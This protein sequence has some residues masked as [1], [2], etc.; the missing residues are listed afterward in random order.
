[1]AN[2]KFTPDSA[3]S[4]DRFSMQN[5]LILAEQ[6]QHHGC[7]CQAYEDYFTY[8][9]WAGQGFQ[10]QKGQHGTKLSVY[11]PVKKVLD[12]EEKVV[13]SR[14]WSSTVFCRCQ[15]APKAK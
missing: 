8:A 13:G 7:K 4:F 5:A 10:V 12:G 6:S 15:V 11:I 9:R 3:K 1:M 14:P 2:Q